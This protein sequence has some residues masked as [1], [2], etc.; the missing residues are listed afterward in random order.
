MA[1]KERSDDERCNDPHGHRHAQQHSR[2]DETK[3]VA[4]AGDRKAAG[5]EQRRATRNAH[6]CQ[7][8]DEW[9]QQRAHYSQDVAR[10]RGKIRKLETRIHDKE[11]AASQLSHERTTLADRLREDYGIELAELEHEPTPEELH[12]RDEVDREIADLRAKLNSIGSVNLDALAELDELEARYNNLSSQHQDLS[13]AKASLEQIIGKINA[14]SRR[15]FA[16]TLEVVRGHFQ[17]LFR[18]LFGGGQADI[19]LDQGVD[20]L[21]S[22]IEIVARPPGKEPRNISLLS[23]GEK[24]LT[25]VALLLAIFRSRPSPFCVLDEVDAA[26]DEAN[27]ERFI[28]VLQEFLAWTQFIVVT[29]S[30]KTMT[31]ASTLY[32]ITMQ[33]SGV[34]KRVSVRFEDV[35]DTGEILRTRE[36]PSSPRNSDEQAA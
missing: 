17:S 22:G 26:L 4:E 10:L 20:I 23:G 27:I 19:V 18:K 2:A 24:T 3:P 7:R 16:D 21:E 34:S 5:P 14:D 9:R 11:L 12:E 30:K 36:E 32:G 29:H 25:C 28:S 1:D 13:S 35:S 8:R 33:E 15:L 6:H 31:C